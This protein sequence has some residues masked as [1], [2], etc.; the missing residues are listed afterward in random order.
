MVLDRVGAYVRQFLESPSGKGQLIMSLVSIDQLLARGEA[1][2]VGNGNT[3][4]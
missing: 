2:A 4:A 3:A 1:A